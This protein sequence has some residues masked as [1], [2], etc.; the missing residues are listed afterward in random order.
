M[1]PNICC[2]EIPCCKLDQFFK[3]AHPN[4][5]HDVCSLMMVG[6]APSHYILQQARRKRQISQVDQGI[7]SSIASFPSNTPTQPHD[8]KT[9]TAEQSHL[10]LNPLLDE[11]EANTTGASLPAKQNFVGVQLSGQ[12]KCSRSTSPLLRVDFRPE[13]LGSTATGKRKRG[14]IQLH[15]RMRLGTISLYD[16]P[17][18]EGI[19]TT[20]DTAP[21]DACATPADGNPE[22]D[23][24]SCR[25]AQASIFGCVTGALLC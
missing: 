15:V 9:G 22:C 11:G 24:T 12:V 14:G 7:S 8:A 25:A 13:A 16:I 3:C 20:L 6:L 19:K 17:H 4:T 23:E 21:S 5:L 1:P 2:F 18:P 10:V